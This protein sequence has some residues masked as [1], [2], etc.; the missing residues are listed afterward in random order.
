MRLTKLTL[1]ALLVLIGFSIF[2]AKVSNLI[3]VNYDDLDVFDEAHGG[4]G[5]R[6]NV[7]NPESFVIADKPEPLLWF[8]QVSDLTLKK[9]VCKWLI[10]RL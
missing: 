9:I 10:W 8:V 5:Q 7:P 4:P 1:L 3:R 6:R 2:L